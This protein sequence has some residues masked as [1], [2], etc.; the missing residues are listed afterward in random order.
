MAQDY[1][2]Y[3][4]SEPKC[5]NVT[6]PM[7]GRIMPKLI[8]FERRKELM[9]MAAIFADRVVTMKVQPHELRL[10]LS[11]VTTLLDKNEYC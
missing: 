10:F 1:D 11:T 6:H 3:K 2:D 5:G 7:Q 8:S 4:D 9:S